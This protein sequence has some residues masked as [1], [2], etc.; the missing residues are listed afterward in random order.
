M[1]TETAT[2]TLSWLGFPVEV[3]A[4]RYFGSQTAHHGVYGVEGDC[5]HATEP[6]C[7]QIDA[8]GNRWPGTV[9]VS[10]TTGVR[11]TCVRDQSWELV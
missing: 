2:V 4:A 1:E 7:S 10:P 8:A 9:L 3:P 5:E 11:L 6:A